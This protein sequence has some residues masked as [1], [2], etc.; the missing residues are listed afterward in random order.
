[1]FPPYLFQLARSRRGGQS[2]FHLFE[3]DG[4][5]ALGSC[6]RIN[7]CSENAPELSECSI[8]WFRLSSEDV[9]KALI[10]GFHLQSFFLFWM[11]W[12]IEQSTVDAS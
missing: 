12:T 4:S 7:P 11:L 10:S 1:M 2:M 9:K 6:L 3:L 8:Q 5:E